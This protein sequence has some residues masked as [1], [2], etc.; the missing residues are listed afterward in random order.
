VRA[1][2]D[3]RAKVATVSTRQARGRNIED[4]LKDIQH[5]ILVAVASGEPLPRVMDLVCRRAEEVAQSAICSVLHVDTA[6]CLHPLAAPSLPDA[7]SQAIDGFKIG[8]MAGSC[9]SAAFLGE[10]VEVVNIK[11]DPRWADFRDAALA[12]GLKACWSSPI[13]SHE[14]RVIGTFAFYFRRARRASQ[15]EKRIVARCAHV[16]AIAIEHWTAQDRIRRLAYADPLT[17]LGNRTLLAEKFPE[18]LKWARARGKKVAVFYVDLNGFRTINAIRGHKIGDRLLCALAERIRETCPEVDLIARLG[19]DEVLVVQAEKQS[20]AEF[21]TIASTLSRT[22][23]EPYSLGSNIDLKVGVSIGVARFPDDGVD[24]DALM[25]QA[26]TALRQVK[27]TGRSGHAFYTVKLDAERRARQAFE[28]DVAAAAAA[29][30][31]SLAFQPQADARTCAVKGFEALLRWNHPIH[32]FVSP[33][34]FI[35][36]AE[37]CGAI[38]DIGV[39]VLRQALSQARK[40]PRHLRVAVNVSPA[41]IAHPDFAR[42]VGDALDGAAVEPSRL[43]LEVTEGLFISDAEA[44]LETLNKVKALGVSVAIDDFGTGYSSLSTLRSF[45]FDRIKIDRSFIV[46]MTT[47]E[48]AAAIVNAIMGLGRAMGRLVIAEGVE[49]AEQLD[50]LQRQGCN[51][52]QGYLIGKPLP[53]ECYSEVMGAPLAARPYAPGDKR[54]SGRHA[55]TATA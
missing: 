29:G 8:P 28:K 20:S 39:F 25:G 16:C 41:Q 24:L 26:D 7:Y 6:G 17:G 49:T 13:K 54:L 33:E 52:V 50:H 55:R 21:E 2:L 34:K 35:P 44:A 12:L 10:P 32:G 40:W 46:D 36:A 23:S 53:I 18:I 37:A 48:H 27:S 4:R 9:G 11:T 30:Q 38:A 15:L 47:N 14:G 1:G 43:E 31:L 51:E 45:P 42:V 3:L 22:L 5:E 19:A